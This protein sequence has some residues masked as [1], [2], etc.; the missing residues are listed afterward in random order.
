MYSE[1]SMAFWLLLRLVCRLPPGNPSFHIFPGS[2]VPDLRITLWSAP[3][4]P[5]QV[6]VTNVRGVGVPSAMFFYIP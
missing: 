2:D 3:A 5:R 1:K 6:V 4:V